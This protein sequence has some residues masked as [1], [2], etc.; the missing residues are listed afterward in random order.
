MS[1]RSQQSKDLRD[2]MQPDR[3]KFAISQ[4]EKAGIKLHYLDEKEI[5]FYWKGSFV[6]FFPFTGW[7]TGATIKDAALRY[8]KMAV[9][10]HKE[11]ANLNIIK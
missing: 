11:F 3:M 5:Q 7:H 9:M 8:N 2:I 4:L 6:K 10:Y 1:R